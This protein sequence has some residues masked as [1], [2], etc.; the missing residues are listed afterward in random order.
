MADLEM[1][2][3]L[4]QFGSFGLVAW[5]FFWTY[6]HMIPSLH[7][8]LDRAID[9]FERALEQQHAECNVI[10]ERQQEKFDALLEEYRQLMV[11]ISDRRHA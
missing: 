6:T 7:D 8:R 11:R 4:L 2:K 10:L 3:G 1:L 5:L 9:R